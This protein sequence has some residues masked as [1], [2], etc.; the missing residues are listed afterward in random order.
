MLEINEMIFF[1]IVLVAFFVGAIFAWSMT[2]A[3]RK[4][5]EE[6]YD[7]KHSEIYNTIRKETKNEWSKG[8]E[9]AYKQ[10]GETNKK[11][12]LW[13]KEHGYEIEDIAK[14][15]EQYQSKP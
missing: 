7:K 10:F 1:I 14:W 5:L 15:Y 13:F 3:Y 6:T 9:S 12:Y 2:H 4:D 11:Y 8:W